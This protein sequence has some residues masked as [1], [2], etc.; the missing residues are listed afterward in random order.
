MRAVSPKRQGSA[1]LVW[2]ICSQGCTWQDKK[3][4]LG[5][6]AGQ[7]LF[8][9]ALVIQG[10]MKMRSARTYLANLADAYDEHGKMTSN[11]MCCGALVFSDKRKMRQ[12]ISRAQKDLEDI[13]LLMQRAKSDALYA[14]QD[15]DHLQGGG[16]AKTHFVEHGGPVLHSYSSGQAKMFRDA[17]ENPVQ[18]TVKGEPDQNESRERRGTKGRRSDESAIG[19]Q[20]RREEASSRGFVPLPESQDIL[21]PFTSNSMADETFSDNDATLFSTTLGRVQEEEVGDLRASRTTDQTGD[22][23]LGMAT[24][25]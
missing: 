4:V 12:A 2:A 1:I 8:E 25:E 20:P 16:I 19:A 15:L 7:H 21:S 11:S 24:C 3:G 17:L 10:T 14:F 22:A 6:E 18:Q 23:G 5:A 9:H 13:K